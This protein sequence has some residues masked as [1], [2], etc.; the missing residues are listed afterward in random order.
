MNK[1]Y[2][3]W[4]LLLVLMPSFLSAGNTGTKDNTKPAPVQ[5]PEIE[6]PPLQISHAAFRTLHAQRI[7]RVFNSRGVFDPEEQEIIEEFY[8][9]SCG[10]LTYLKKNPSQ[11]LP[12]TGLKSI[13]DFVEF[14]EDALKTPED[15]YEQIEAIPIVII[16]D[17]FNHRLYQLQESRIPKHENDV[18]ELHRWWHELLA[19]GQYHENL[20]Q[21]P[22]MPE[23]AFH[24]VDQALT[25]L[26]GKAR[27]ETCKAPPVNKQLAPNICV[28]Q[29]LPNFKR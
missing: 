27:I 17:F 11:R 4:V 24:E 19:F 2:M 13:I 21:T 22:C 28:F 10:W 26:E 7:A 29:V 5:E 20:G 9:T 25:Y 1:H 15:G 23:K 12:L 8:D 18:K 3:A 14:Y 6:V 16:R